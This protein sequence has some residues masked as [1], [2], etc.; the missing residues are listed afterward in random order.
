MPIEPKQGIQI[1]LVKLGAIGKSSNAG[2][3]ELNSH[4][5]SFIPKLEEYLEQ[6]KLKPMEYDVVG[7]V[8]VGEVLAAL[9][10]F[11]AKKS[12]DKKIVVRIAA[13]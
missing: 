10:A 2:E 9:D 3:L 8:G 12:G 5:S 4:I 1:Y 13:D 11:N 6:G 7:N